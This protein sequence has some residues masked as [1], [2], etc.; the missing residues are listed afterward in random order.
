MGNLVGRVDGR[1]FGFLLRLLRSLGFLR[2]AAGIQFVDPSLAAGAPTPTWKVRV[3]F[4]DKAMH[5]IEKIW[6]FLNLID[7]HN[8]LMGLIF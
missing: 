7:H 4:L 8:F 5:N 3:A 1:R 2:G 6:S